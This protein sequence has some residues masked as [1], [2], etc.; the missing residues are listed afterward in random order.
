[1]LYD[2]D[3]GLCRWSA[4]KVLAWD[5]NGRVRAVAL[6]DPEAERLLAELSPERRPASWHLV[7]ADGHVN[8]AGAAL[9]PLL[10]LLPGGR[11][12][13]VVAELSPALTERLYRLVARNRSRLSRLVGSDACET[14]T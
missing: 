10:R 2:R 3:C 12:L 13:A 11:P 4:S 6:Q 5:R 1:M 7:T 9:A 8:S 14:Q